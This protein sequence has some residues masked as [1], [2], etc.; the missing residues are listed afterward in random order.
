M[1]NNLSS[2]LVIIATL[3]EEEGI[4]PTIAEIQR[5]IYNP[6]ILV[7]D[8][9][10]IDKTVEVAKDMGAEVI[11]QKGKGKGDAIS[12]A[13]R[14]VDLNSVDY[15][16]FIDGDYTYPASSLPEMI[17]I[18]ESDPKIGMVCGNRFTRDLNLGEHHKLLFLGNRAIAFMHRL[19]NNVKLHDP[20]TGLR[21]VR[22]EVLKNWKPKSKG[23]DIEVELNKWV[24]RKGYSIAEIPIKYRKRL[25][26]K[27]LKL[28]HAL[29]ILRR[30]LGEIFS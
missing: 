7:V 20:L 13:I 23:F 17:K 9:R 22:A 29:T 1:V 10:S 4:G 14:H 27:K 5:S 28:R 11:I 30:I 19:L 24:K 16:T 8:G 18:L 21:A 26:E 2:I 15:V 12:Q 6:R 3:N 25:G